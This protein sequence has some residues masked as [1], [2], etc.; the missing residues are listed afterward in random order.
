MAFHCIPCRR[1]VKRKGEAK[2]AMWLSSYSGNSAY[3][4]IQKVSHKH[5]QKGAVLSCREE[6]TMEQ[7]THTRNR[8]N[9]GRYHHRLPRLREGGKPFPTVAPCL[10]FHFCTS[11]LLDFQ[12]ERFK[13]ALMGCCWSCGCYLSDK[14]CKGKVW[15][16]PMILLV[17]IHITSGL[18]NNRRELWIGL[19]NCARISEERHARYHW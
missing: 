3:A 10:F 19:W 14:E 9:P 13:I 6:V 12:E 4:L 16:Y 7:V 1:C 11:P 8:D 2:I 15:P 5:Y 17:C 18:Y